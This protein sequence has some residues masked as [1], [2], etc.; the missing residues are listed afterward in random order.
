MIKAFVVCTAVLL[1]LLAAGIVLKWRSAREVIRVT[2]EEAA[3]Q[4]ARET[5]EGRHERH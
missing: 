4:R 1:I 5:G 2:E 3:E